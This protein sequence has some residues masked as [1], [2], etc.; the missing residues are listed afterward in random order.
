MVNTGSLALLHKKNS[1]CSRLRH[2]KVMGSHML[3]SLIPS[4]EPE[5]TMVLRNLLFTS[6]EVYMLIL[7]TSCMYRFLF[8]LAI[9]RV[10]FLKEC[11][12]GLR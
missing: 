10:N 7:Y 5:F 9:F 1:G 6:H 2:F 11:N 12:K 8:A 3:I 4:I